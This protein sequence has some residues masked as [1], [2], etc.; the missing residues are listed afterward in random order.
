[1]SVRT[2]M[3]A[4]GAAATMAT[5]GLLAAPQPASAVT[6]VQNYGTNFRGPTAMADCKAFGD[7]GRYNG[8]WDFYRCTPMTG[9]VLMAG[10]VYL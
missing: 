5:V 7:A 9:Y 2:R 8:R 1:M 3:A 4:L 6:Y 10:Y